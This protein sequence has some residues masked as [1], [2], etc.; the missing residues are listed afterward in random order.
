MIKLV[1]PFLLLTAVFSQS[2][3]QLNYGFDVGAGPSLTTIKEQLSND[4]IIFE[5]YSNPTGI[6]LGASVDYKINESMILSSGLRLINKGTG[7]NYETVDSSGYPLLDSAW[8]RRIIFKTW[9]LR[10]PLYF[11]YYH[12]F[13]E[14]PNLIPFGRLGTSVDL[15]INNS[16]PSGLGTNPPDGFEYLDRIDFSIVIGLGAQFKSRSNQVYNVSI[17]YYAA[18]NNAVT[19]SYETNDDELKIR[20][21]SIQ[22]EFGY[23]FGQ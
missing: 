12:D 14:N 10:L 20:N 4:A 3:G 1:I 15:R 2:Y 16:S 18:L 6:Q 9:Y 19:A 21:N 23:R 5:R 11:Q 8:N 7:V 13:F 17:N 22:L